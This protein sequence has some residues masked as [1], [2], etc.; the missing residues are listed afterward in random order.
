MND[1]F[2][3]S[4]E[5]RRNRRFLSDVLE[6]GVSLSF[7]AEVVDVLYSGI[8][9]EMDENI[10]LKKGKE[11]VL[12]YRGAPMIAIVQYAERNETGQWRIGM[13]WKEPTQISTG[14]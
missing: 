5:Q 3:N 13:K 9:L 2:S 4:T 12:D 7:P 6:V 10:P 11:I 14:T 8:A 1:E